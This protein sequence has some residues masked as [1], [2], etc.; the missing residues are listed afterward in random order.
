[1]AADSSKTLQHT[2]RGLK[3]VGSKSLFDLDEPNW[4]ADDKV[5]SSSV[6]TLYQLTISL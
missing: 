5:G 2:R 1:M 6:C 3:L 4:I